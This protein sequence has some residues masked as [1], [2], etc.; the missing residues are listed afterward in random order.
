LLAQASIV[1]K[2][3][4]K[5]EG[6][7]YG[8]NVYDVCIEGDK[9]YYKFKHY[10]GVIHLGPPNSIP[11]SYLSN[12]NWQTEAK[13]KIAD[14]KAESERYIKLRQTYEEKYLVPEFV[15]IKYLEDI[16]NG[17]PSPERLEYM[18]LKKKFQPMLIA[19]NMFANPNC[20][21]QIHYKW[22]SK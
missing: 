21:G 19:N 10:D 11:L 4:I 20:S 17:K 15:V 6:Y 16:E 18:A 12:P 8:Y 3:Y 13:V 5:T 14:G 9:I 2:E 1:C 7:D 22:N